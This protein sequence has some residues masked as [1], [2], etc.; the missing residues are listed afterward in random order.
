[1]NAACTAPSRCFGEAA[2]M[3]RMCALISDDSVPG[4]VMKS[5]G[6]ERERQ[7]ERKKK[8]EQERE[9]SRA[10]REP[11]QHSHRSIRRLQYDRGV[12]NFTTLLG[13]MPRFCWQ[14]SCFDHACPWCTKAMPQENVAH[15]R[16][17]FRLAPLQQCHMQARCVLY[18]FDPFH[19]CRA[20][21]MAYQ[22]PCL[23]RA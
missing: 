7:P 14:T 16:K 19:R 23:I 15:Y 3:C 22:Q 8:Q 5:N 17:G 2:A 10:V 13:C 1:M 20:R 21:G 12:V 6:G 18:L 11:P 9:Q 4:K